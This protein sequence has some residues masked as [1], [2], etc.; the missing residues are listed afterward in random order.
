MGIIGVPLATLSC[1]LIISTWVESYVLHKHVMHKSMR[2][3]VYRYLLFSLIT[4][5]DGIIVYHLV[6]LV[7]IGGVG[8]FILK[9][10][11]TVTGASVCLII[12]S[13]WMKE[14]KLVLVIIRGNLLHMI[15][16]FKKSKQIV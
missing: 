12:T 9:L 6:G 3:Y 15:R 14:F 5:I 2:H 8:G 11:I 4:L 13:L 7:I 1:Q 16:A 10:F